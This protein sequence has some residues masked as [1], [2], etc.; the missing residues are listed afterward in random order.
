MI[1]RSVGLSDDASAFDKNVSIFR[2]VPDLLGWKV[3]ARII[4]VVQYN[5]VWIRL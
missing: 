1:I 4:S 5:I 2:K 3:L